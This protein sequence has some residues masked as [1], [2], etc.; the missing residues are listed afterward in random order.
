MNSKQVKDTHQLEN[1]RNRS[2]HMQ[3]VIV[4]KYGSPEVLQVENVP[5]PRPK[6]NEVLIKIHAST[7]TT[8]D[9]VTRKGEP[10][11]ARFFTGLRKPKGI[12]G[13]ELAGEIV[14]VGKDVTEFK[15]GDKVFGSTG[16]TSGANAEYICLPQ[17]GII[18]LKPNNVSYEEA[19]AIPFGA[20]T[21]LA[22]LRDK[23]EIQCG[24]KVMIYGASGSV[25]SAAVQIAKYFG[26]EV[27]GVCS[28]TNVEMVKALGADKVIDYTKDDTIKY[29]NDYDIIFDA[30]GKT[31]YANCK[32]LI[33]PDGRFISVALTPELVF[34]SLW[35]SVVGRK[36]VKWGIIFGNVE[37]LHYVQTLMQSGAIKA[38]V[39]RCYP[40]DA[41][42]DAHRYVDTGRKKGNVVIKVA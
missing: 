11:I 13:S 4:T 22:F 40:I 2:N 33:K 8:G 14:A 35:T 16:M 24:Q 39:D 9:C 38:V 3:A 6:D 31:T 41:I 34:Q 30:V 7:V 23:G 12:L 5:Q 1:T 37:D 28:G 17:D 18:A 29:G 42:G 26:A 20:T 21:A 36:K 10:F 27:V 15:Q 32:A 19:T 25:G